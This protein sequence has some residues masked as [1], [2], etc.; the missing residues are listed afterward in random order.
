MQ[1]LGQVDVALLPIGGTFTMDSNE[2]VA[3]AMAI[4]PKV[5]IPMHRFKVDPQKLAK[6]IEARSVIKLI[7]LDIGEIYWMED[8]YG[9][10]LQ[11]SIIILCEL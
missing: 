7:S 1:E 4:N 6:E 2:A 8:K 10:L 11:V 3:A 9:S 5:V